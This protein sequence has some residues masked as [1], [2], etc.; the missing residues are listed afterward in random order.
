MTRRARDEAKVDVMK[1]VLVFA[2]P[3]L[4]ACCSAPRWAGEM[5]M[6]VAPQRTMMAVDTDGVTPAMNTEGYDHFDDND[7]L[8]VAD[9]PLSTFSIDV[10]TAS[11]SNI[12]RLLAQGVLPVKGAVR[13]EEMINYFDYR[14]AAPAGDAPFGV[15]VEIAQAP[16]NP[17]NRLVR[18]GLN[19]RR[20]EASQRPASN[21]VFLLDVSGS[22]SA[23]NKLPLLQQSLKLLVD[24]LDERDSV[25]IVVYAGASGVVLE[26]TSAANSAEILAALDRLSAGGSTNGGA[27]IELA[28][29]LARQRFIQGG[30]N[31]VILATDGDFNVGATSRSALI[32]LVQGQAKSGVFLSVLGLG[33]GNYKDSTLEQIANK[34]NGHYAYI[35]TIREAKK[36]L[37]DEMTATL[38]TIAKDVK[39]QVEMNPTL[40]S[41]YRLIGYENR[42]MRADEF[43]DDTKD[44]GEIGAGHTVTAL[45]E[46]VPRIGDAAKG[47]PAL[48]YQSDRGLKGAAQ[49]GELMTIK[50]RY[51]APEGS[52]STALAF[53]I[54]DDG[55]T[56]TIAQASHDFR[57]AAAVAAF[58]MLLRDSPH[59]GEATYDAAL[60]WARTAT[61]DDLHGYR[62][63]LVQLIE[64]A[65]TL[66][67]S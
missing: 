47:G 5:S 58:G 64:K 34:G 14:Y 18:I 27:G 56:K 28:Y 37:V 15:D 13:I 26:P 43:D 17:K 19:G 29:Q 2:L 25:A 1:R 12:R 21:L 57:F 32:D 60:E 52:K 4:F 62:R 6:A 50:V 30:T 24:R 45:Y 66:A 46:V 22:M 38:V 65:A 23:P 51:K 31:R 61:G 10:D 54:T 48:R 36:L 3:M 35:D 11:Y 53:A 44:A 40:V 9:Q 7:F 8:A 63:E 41:S 20:I 49:S 55:Q 42:V 16:W 67:G 33:M 59:K 39:I